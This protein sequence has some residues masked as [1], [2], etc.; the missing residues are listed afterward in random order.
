[1]ISTDEFEASILALTAN[2]NVLTLQLT[3]LVQFLEKHEFPMNEYRASL[4]ENQQIRMWK[5]IAKEEN[6]KLKLSS[7]KDIEDIL[8]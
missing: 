7:Q 5:R 1:M 4:D 2:V 6:E 8:Q 3:L